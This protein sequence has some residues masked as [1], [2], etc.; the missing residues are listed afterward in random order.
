M[1]NYID[2]IIEKYGEQIKIG[3]QNSDNTV[4]GF[5][6]PLNYEKNDFGID[7]RESGL[8]NS[9]HYVFLGKSD[10]EVD[11]LD[12]GTIFILNGKKYQKEFSEIRYFGDSSICVRA[13]L[14]ILGENNDQ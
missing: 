2:S 11:S 10:C 12:L 1:F 4:K 5:I 14:R 6:Y 13:V 9:R 7:A 3:D 8:Y